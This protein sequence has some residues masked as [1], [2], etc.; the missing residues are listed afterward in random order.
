MNYDRVILELLDRVSALEETV[1]LLKSESPPTDVLMQESQVTD[2]G[3]EQVDDYS[4]AGVRDTTKYIFE[5]KRYGKNRL[6]LAVVQRYVSNNPGIS[7]EKLMATFD[8][9][10]QGSLGVLRLADEA[11][12]S[13]N[14]YARRFFFQPN[15]IVH[16]STNDCVVCTQW[17]KFNIGSFIARAEQLGMYI[18]TVGG[19]NV[20]NS[21][22]EKMNDAFARSQLIGQDTFIDLYLD[23]LQSLHEN[24]RFM[25]FVAQLRKKLNG[26]ELSNTRAANTE[27]MNAFYYANI[28]DQYE[29]VA[30]IVN[31][32]KQYGK[33]A[34][35]H[36][37]IY[38]AM[39]VLDFGN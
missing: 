5:G 30:D 15:E 39:Y 22:G 17:G 14:D 23:D 3:Y 12:R 11:R 29:E 6:V 35:A 34:S 8:R 9:S 19:G 37:S 26:A 2:F 36:I 31:R 16:T 25:A 32:V 27:I 10:I 20:M 18:Q 1:A 13:Y 21:N 33:Q 28:N 4:V 7:A 38:Y 24:A